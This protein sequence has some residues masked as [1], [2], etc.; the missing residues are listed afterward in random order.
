MQQRNRK[1][2]H[3]ER[4]D[5]LGCCGKRGSCQ[6]A[7]RRQPR[8]KI[9]QEQGASERGS[10]CLKA[11]VRISPYRTSERKFRLPRC[12]KH[13]PIRTRAPFFGLLPRLI[14]GFDQKV[15]E[16]VGCRSRNELPYKSSLRA[17]RRHRLLDGVATAGVADFSD[18]NGFSRKPRAHSRKPL[19]RFIDCRRQPHAFPIRQQMHC[20]EVHLIG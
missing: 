17:R 18:Q 2:G 15:I 4:Q 12:V 19:Q 3:S 10:Q 6:R 16:S 8:E 13:T 5:A 11:P 7:Q 9:Q 20:D 1:D 14:V